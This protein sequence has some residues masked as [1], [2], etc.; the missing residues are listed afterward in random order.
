MHMKNEEIILPRKQEGST[1]SSIN[2]DRRRHLIKQ[3]QVY[4]SRRL[5]SKQIDLAGRS[6]A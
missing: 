6:L 3:C 1:V 2:C 5:E 4:L